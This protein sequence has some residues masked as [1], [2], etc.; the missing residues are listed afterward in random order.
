[1]DRRAY[2]STLGAAALAGFA[3]CNTNEGT[4]GEGSSGES[5]TDTVVTAADGPP[6]FE[7]VEINGPESVTIGE[8]FSLNIQA[9]NTGG[10]AGDFTATLTVGDGFASIDQGIQ[11]SE[12]P[13]GE[14]KST[15]I[16]PLSF[17]AAQSLTFRIT[18]YAVEHELAVETLTTT[19]GNSAEFAG[20]DIDISASV[21]GYQPSFF[22]NYSPALSDETL[23]GLFHADMDSTLLAVD[24]QVENQTDENIYLDA[25]TLSLGDTNPIN[26]ELPDKTFN[27]FIYG[28][29]IAGNTVSP[30]SS[31][32][33]WIVFDVETESISDNI[34]LSWDASASSEP[35]VAWIE[36]KPPAL[37]E[38]TFET[39]QI[40]DSLQIGTE[41]EL[42]ATVQNI[43]D[44]DG[45]FRGLVQRRNAGDQQWLPVQKIDQRIPA[46][47]SANVSV[48]TSEPY[49]GDSE[50]RFLPSTTTPTV[51]FTAAQRAFGDSYVSPDD[52]A[53]TVE[54]TTFSDT[55]TTEEYGS[56]TYEADGTFAFINVTAR[57]IGDENQGAY[58]PQFFSGVVD[59]QSY[60]PVSAYNIADPVSGPKYAGS[61][62]MHPGESESGWIV[63]DIPADS[64]VRDFRAQLE[65]EFSGTIHVKANWEASIESYTDL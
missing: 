37:P 33:G 15:E 24:L 3:G 65:R 40:P 43:G 8:D 48:T 13:R 17:E 57:N 27:S 22:Y 44:A 9:T 49:I 36:T 62:G 58:A 46:G 16:G 52:V 29:T 23:T 51:S 35:E 6:Y 5:N 41:G 38:F 26:D 50:Y 61:F 31:V 10:R 7:R 60:S 28:T 19:F 11:I 64:S 1:M 53:Y 20:G 54:L 2:I 4:D 21:R 39:L 30:N 42:T 14:S 45:E 12:I 47:E 18:D 25:E 56:P 55:Y 32:R 63:F 34:R 59:G